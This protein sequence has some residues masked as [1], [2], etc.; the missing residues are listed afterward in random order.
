MR[1]CDLNPDQIET[2][3]PKAKDVKYLPPYSIV[4]AY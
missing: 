3:F 2:V 4:V 1:S